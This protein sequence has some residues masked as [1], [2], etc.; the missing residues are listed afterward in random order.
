MQSK[1]TIHEHPTNG[2][3]DEVLTQLSK[4]VD[5]S[6][7]LLD[8]GVENQFANQIRFLLKDPIGFKI[9]DSKQ[10]LEMLGT[11]FVIVLLRML[12][13]HKL[14]GI[15]SSL[16]YALDGLNLHLYVMVKT[17]HWEFDQRYPLY[18]YIGYL[19][20]AD[21]FRELKIDINIVKESEKTE[22]PKEF[23]IVNISDMG[24]A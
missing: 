7:F 12:Q 16:R 6:R 11:L 21:I 2:Q 18:N 3:I 19:W 17:P 20:S 5:E 1:I 14:I 9:K 23:R 24:N 8:L 13:D 10:S 22:L 4:H 15:I